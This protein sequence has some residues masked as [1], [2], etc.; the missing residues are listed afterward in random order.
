[1]KWDY[2]YAIGVLEPDVVVQMW[3]GADAAEEI[4]DQSYTVVEM[5]GMLFSARTDSPHIRWNLVE[6]QP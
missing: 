2:P 5:N 1:M 4:L 6:T 3:D